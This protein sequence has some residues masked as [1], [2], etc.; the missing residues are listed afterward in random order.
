MAQS[1]V[2][3]KA[4][5]NKYY[6]VLVDHILA[7]TNGELEARPDQLKL[8]T[9]RVSGADLI[10]AGCDI[11]WLLASGAIEELGYEPA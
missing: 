3:T 2:I 4:A 1:K 8:L 9:G 7:G 6:Q 11:K 10:A 5:Q